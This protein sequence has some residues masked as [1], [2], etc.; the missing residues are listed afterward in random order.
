MGDSAPRG[1]PPGGGQEL[2][3]IWVTPDELVR[4]GLAAALDE[5]A[6]G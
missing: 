1:D 2:D 6:T 4:Y 3:T 5:D